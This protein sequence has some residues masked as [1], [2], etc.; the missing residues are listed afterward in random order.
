VS[1]STYTASLTGYRLAPLL[2]GDTIERVALR[3]LGDAR[4]WR[5]LANVNGLLWPY[6]TDDPAA[7][8]ATVLLTS[9]T[10]KV[11]AA[12]AAAPSAVTDDTLLGTDLL[13]VGGQLQVLNGDLAVVSGEQNLI[14]AVVR[15]LTVRLRELP[16]YP[17]YGTLLR[18]LIGKRGNAST[19]QLAGSYA[20]SSIASDPRIES[21]S[22]TIATIKGDSIT[23]T[24]RAVS[25]SGKVLPT[26]AI[27]VPN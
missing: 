15:R 18:T 17:W 12:Q 20:A 10:I 11:P 24:T 9:G 2:Q 7:A 1:G 4:S 14:A 8:S 5:V 6:V 23:V 27:N 19:D 22:N 13:M 3:E 26:G 16:Y 21:V 25:V